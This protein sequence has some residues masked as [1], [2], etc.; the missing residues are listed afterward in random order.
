M[1]ATAITRRSAMREVREASYPSAPR[2][3]FHRYYRGGFTSC[4]WQPGAALGGDEFVRDA[5]RGGATL[6]PLRSVVLEAAGC[7]SAE[8][9]R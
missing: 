9:A 1:L 4:G 3:L 2:A 5:V 6:R 8:R 7:Q